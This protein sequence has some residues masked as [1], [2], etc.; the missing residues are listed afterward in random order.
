MIKSLLNNIVLLLAILLMQGCGG[1][2]FAQNQTNRSQTIT[3]LYKNSD[4]AT[5]YSIDHYE[6]KRKITNM[7]KECDSNTCKL[8]FDLLPNK[9]L[10]LTTILSVSHLST[11]P[12]E[13]RLVYLNGNNKTGEVDTILYKSGK[14][15]EINRFGQ[16]GKIYSFLTLGLGTKTFLYEFK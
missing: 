13:E 6:E 4:Q 14:K 3:I 16:R 1:V 11:A 10:P 8:T 7:I 2:Y 5:H 9:N 12:R 15:M